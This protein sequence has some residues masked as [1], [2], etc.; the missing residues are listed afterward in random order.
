MN[1]GE[2]R[3]NIIQMLSKCYINHDKKAGFKLLIEHNAIIS[4]TNT[5]E[6]LLIMEQLY[7]KNFLNNS[8]LNQFNFE[9]IKNYLLEE[10]TRI[11]N[12]KKEDL[13]DLKT[14]VVAYCGIGL[15]LLQEVD[16]AKEIYDF[17]SQNCLGN[18]DMWGTYI[19]NSNADIYSTYIVTMLMNR[20][21]LR[22]QCPSQFKEILS[23][24]SNL[25]IP[26]SKKSDNKYV[27]ALTIAIYMCKYYYGC[28]INSRDVDII[29]S[30]YSNRSNDI[31]KCIESHFSVHPETQYHVFSFGLA[32]FVIYDIKS[33]FFMESNH[34]ILEM[35]DENFINMPRKNIPFCLELCRL[36]N[37]IKR[38]YDPFKGELVIDEVN[39][40]QSKLTELTKNVQEIKEQVMD[41]N[42]SFK[43]KMSICILVT[44]IYF[45]VTFSIIY[46][47]VRGMI[48]SLNISESNVLLN[49]G[50]QLIGM[51][52]S[53]VI[54]GLGYLWR[55]TRKLLVKIINYILKLIKFD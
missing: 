19:L 47:L 49:I 14:N 45:G 55:G 26:Y 8:E 41:A 29:N 39:T 20:L 36:Y 5:A 18:E 42:D 48:G 12:L 17:I 15:I 27:E 37:A 24:S 38:R 31:Y 4:T 35:L 9:H 11:L 50:F 10:K 28:D 52:V 30:Y 46:C 23:N 25:G 34:Y 51:M 2:F 13:N 6:A 43:I 40:L 7:G 22:C 32:A 3:D 16:A 53:V 54:P 33:P 21:H 1:Q 44:F